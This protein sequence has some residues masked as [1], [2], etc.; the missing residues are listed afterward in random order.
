MVMGGPAH[1]D[2]LTGFHVVASVG[3]D[4]TVHECVNGLLRRAASHRCRLSELP[5]LAVVPCGSG[6][7]FAFDLGIATA[8]QA[9]DKI[10]QFRK[11]G[12]LGMKRALA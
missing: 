3:G 1:T 9:I 10:L 11:V 5:A 6:N 7:T 4:G 8:Q 12:V 2:D